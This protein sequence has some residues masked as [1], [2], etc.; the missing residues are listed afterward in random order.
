MDRAQRS[1]TGVRGRTEAD[2][3][4]LPI[5]ARAPR[6][7]NPN[8]SPS[9]SPPRF[10]G[11]ARSA[12]PPFPRS[13][14]GGDC[15]AYGRRARGSC[16]GLGGRQRSGVWPTARG[17]RPLGGGRSSILGPVPPVSGAVPRR[18]RRRHAAVL[19]DARRASPPFRSPGRGKIVPPRAVARV[20]RAPA[21]GAFS[22]RHSLSEGSRRGNPV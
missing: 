19:G 11:G 14:P 17:A 18:S 4:N 21:A 5:Y 10:V 15:L 2:H 22:Y 16:G 8:P 6:E 7:V 9:V 1:P 13:R 3:G 20:S 12:P